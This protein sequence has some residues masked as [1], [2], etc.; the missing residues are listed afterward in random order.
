MTGMN[1]E[2]LTPEERLIAEQAVM[3][4]RTLSQACRHAPDGQ[5]LAVAEQMAVE[6]GRELTRRT[7]QASLEHE[8]HALEKKGRRAGCVPAEGAGPTTD[9]SDG[10]S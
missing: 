10:R 3:N 7:L 5:V 1:W 2:A 8:G 4:L 9:A 6:Q